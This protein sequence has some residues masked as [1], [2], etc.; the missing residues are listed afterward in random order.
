[1]SSTRDD[2]VYDCNKDILI[3]NVNDAIV[4]LAEAVV[5]LI[6]LIV[7]DLDTTV[8]VYLNI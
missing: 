8:N 1:M 4:I 7:A 3:D 5:W 6:P 2:I